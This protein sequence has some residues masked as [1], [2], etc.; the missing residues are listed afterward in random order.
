[1]LVNTIVYEGLMVM[2]VLLIHS[3]L[4]VCSHSLVLCVHRLNFSTQP[5]STKD[6]SRFLH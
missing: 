5:Q 2:T 1:M 3:I 6:Q 4:M